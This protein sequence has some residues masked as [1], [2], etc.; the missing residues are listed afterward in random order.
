MLNLISIKDFISVNYTTSQLNILVVISMIGG[1]L[2]ITS[3]N[4]II[5]IFFLIMVF[6]CIS[7][8][9][10]S[11]GL[12]FIGLAYL[13]VYVG[14]VSILFLF[15]LMLIDIRASEMQNNSITSIPLAIFVLFIFSYIIPEVYLNTSLSTYFL[16]LIYNNILHTINTG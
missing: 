7:L 16:D 1:I 2:V 5:S 4:P 8:Y 6:T 9:L 11:I 14:A 3:T 13:L 10:I 15:I 12:T